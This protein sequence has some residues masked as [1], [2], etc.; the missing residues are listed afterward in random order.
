MKEILKYFLEEIKPYKWWYLLTFQTIVFSP[1]YYILY[2]YSIKLLLDVLVLEQTFNITK[3]YL[4]ATIYIGS[5]LYIQ[6]V[7]RLSNFASMKC[8]PQTENRIFLKS[9]NYVLHHSYK[10]FTEIPSGQVMSKIK[11][12]SDGFVNLKNG[13]H[14][15]LGGMIFT[16]ISCIIAICF[17]VPKLGLFI[18]IWSVLFVIISSKLARKMEKISS[19]Q[20]DAKHKINGLVADTIS[21]IQTLFAFAARRREFDFFQKHIK[22]ELLPKQKA[23]WRFEMIFQA[24]VGIL[25]ILFLTGAI[26]AVIYFKINGLISIGDVYFILSLV[27]HFMDTTWRASVEFEV[28]LKNIGDLKASFSIISVQNDVDPLE[29]NII[30]IQNPEICFENISFN[31]DKAEVFN[32]MNLR[33]NAGEKIGLVGLSG[34]GKSTLVSLLLRYNKALSGKITISGQNI[35]EFSKNS[36]REQ[37]AVIPQDIMLFNRTI[38]EN[39]A[40]GKPNASKEEVIEASKKA[41]IHDFIESLPQKYNTMVG[42]RGIKLSGGQRQRIG[43]AR[44]ILKNAKILILDEATSS[45]DSESEGKIQHS[46]ST[47]LDQNITIIAIA[48][49]LA[50]LKHVDRILVLEYGKIIEEGKHEELLLKNGLYTRLWE[51]QKI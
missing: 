4:P 16:A 2:N 51:G 42:E 29:G 3:F 25:Y 8:A 18:F 40:Y 21:N 47:L 37:I 28:F 5:E 6:I 39:I 33:I 7:W 34:A 43:I 27:W 49:R 35:Y 50:T 38:F 23:L 15:N 12:I 36:L 45:L 32:G 17:I 24:I 11:G 48:H 14:Y 22:D 13:L 46:I 20:S 30:K 9:Y 1:L 10:F 19:A 26:I 41:Y 31:Y 44:A